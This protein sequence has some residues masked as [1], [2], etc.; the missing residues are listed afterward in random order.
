MTGVELSYT[1]AFD[2]LL[3]FKTII[4]RNA[5]SQRQEVFAEQ[6][7]AQ[8]RCL[9]HAK[10]NCSVSDLAGAAGV[11]RAHVNSYKRAHRWIILIC[12]SAEIPGAPAMP[13]ELSSGVFFF[14]LATA[15]AHVVLKRTKMTQQPGPTQGTT[16]REI[17]DFL[18]GVKDGN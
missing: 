3:L 8:P 11:I 4:R 9:A 12:M 2:N 13:P 1:S 17:C 5:P 7:S 16:L 10:I 6:T 14:V 18:G 15:R